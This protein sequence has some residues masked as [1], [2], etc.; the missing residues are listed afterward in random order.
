M[1]EREL[2]R[3]RDEKAPFIAIPQI[4]PILHSVW[5]MRAHFSFL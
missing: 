1:K 5:K 3:A 4:A 2:E